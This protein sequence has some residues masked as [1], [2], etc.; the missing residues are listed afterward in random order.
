MPRFAIS[1]FKEIQYFRT[2]LMTPLLNFTAAQ[3]FKL[4]RLTRKVLTCIPHGNQCLN[5]VWRLS[6][7]TDDGRIG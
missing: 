4:D 2:F 3:K 1:R 7:F 6:K 5:K